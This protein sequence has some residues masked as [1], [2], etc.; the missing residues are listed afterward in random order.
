MAPLPENVLGADLLWWRTSGGM[1]T[2]V[3]LLWGRVQPFV[4]EIHV[5]AILFDGQGQAV[6]RWRIEPPLDLPVFIDSAAE[7]PW[8]Q[9][10]GIDGVLALYACTEAAPSAEA[11]AKYNRL[12][13]L[14]DWQ[15]PDGR[16]ATLHSDQVIRRGRNKVQRFT[17]IVIV[18]SAEETNALVLLNGEDT[19][20]G[21]AVEL[22]FQNKNGE[23]RSA[24]YPLPMM[25]FTVH[26]IE[27]AALSPGLAE[28]SGGKPLLVSGN[29]A[30][31]GLYSRPYIE[32]TG[33][34]WGAYHA[35]DLYQWQPTP[36]FVHAMIGGEL[37]PVAVLHDGNTRT[38]V[39]IL[40]SHGNLE[41]DIA[42]D[43]ALFDTDGQ[44]VA[45]RP[46]WR[47]AMRNGLA[48]ADIAELLP[49]PELPFRGHIALNFSPIHGQDVPGHLQALIEYRRPRSVAH[50]MTWSDEW[51]SRVKLAKRDR[52]LSPALYQSWFRVLD[53]AETTTEIAIVNAGHQGYARSAEVHATLCSRAGV[54][55]ETRF[56]LAPYASRFATAEQLFPGLAATHVDR[57]M[58]AIVVESTS[59][60][61][62][63]GFTHHGGGALA[64]EHF[65]SLQSLHDGAI[66]LPAGS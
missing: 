44:C 43:A 52:S 26:R 33:T 4:D 48:R 57:A 40:Q 37:N 30:S 60:L 49:H 5:R 21:S 39:N 16:M 12:F 15:L 58:F 29:F 7:G 64:C 47:I 53:D 25:P 46:A 9:A 63:V 50:T 23:T 28:F 22:V 14:L 20:E 54:V 38:L 11:R 18:E 13:P 41:A 6:A 36:Y 32:T 35:G 24:F 61:A 55:T 42:V 66:I 1:R 31:R 56:T 3:T 8:Q 2:V 19:Q 65:M 59:D 62:S 34:R 17:E 45:R 27:L 10:P 51:N